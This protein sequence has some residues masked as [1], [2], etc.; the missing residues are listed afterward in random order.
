MAQRGRPGLAADQ[1]AEL[2]QR[3]KNGQSL[4]DMGRVPGKHAGSIHGVVFSH[5]GINPAPRVRSIQR[6]AYSKSVPFGGGTT[7]MNDLPSK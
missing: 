4:S 5:G 1:K 6:R 7:H 2:W 3:W